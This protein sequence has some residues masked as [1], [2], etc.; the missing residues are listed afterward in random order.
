MNLS[1]H[2]H[3]L[4]CQDHA[5]VTYEHWSNADFEFKESSVE[6]FHEDF[7]E[8]FINVRYVINP[9]DHAFICGGSLLALD[10]GGGD[11]RPIVSSISIRRISLRVGMVQDR[12]EIAEI[13]KVF[14][15]VNQFGI[16]VDGGVDHVYRVNHT[17]LLDLIDTWETISFTSLKEKS[18]QPTVGQTDFVNCYNNT[19]RAEIISCPPDFSDEW[20]PSICNGLVS[21]V[22]KSYK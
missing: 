5:G 7:H 15:L 9:D 4:H 13:A 1:S 20:E 21:G 14:A 6:D 16:G 10:K 19:Y 11:P 17:A 18:M 12:A 22:H 2:M 8:D 3:R